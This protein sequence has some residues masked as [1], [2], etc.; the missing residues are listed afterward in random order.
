[1]KKIDQRKG[2]LTFFVFKYFVPEYDR[3]SLYSD[4]YNLYEDVLHDKGK[5]YA[6]FWILC[7]IIRSIPG[8][9]SAKIF[10]L[11]TMLKNY[12]KIVI[13]NFKRHK[14]YTIINVSGLAVGI[15]AC[16]LIFQY[17]SFE[18]SFENFH[19]NGNNIYRIRYDA[20][21]KGKLQYK[22]AAAVPA[23][24]PAM[25]NEFS[26]IKNF[27]RI[28]INW[29]SITVLYKDDSTN[30]EISFRQKKSYYADNS[31][32]TMFT[33]PFIHGKPELALSEPYSVV[34]SEDIVKKYFKN[35]PPVGKRVTINGND[36]KVTG[37]FKNILHNSHLKF[38]VI[39][40]L[41]HF[42]KGSLDDWHWD[43]FYTYVLIDSAADP[44][45]IETKL[46]QLIAKYSTKTE[47]KCFLQPLK[48]IHL[49]SHLQV[50][51]ENN[52][53]GTI[54]HFLLIV[55]IIILIIAWVNYINLS[56][57]RSL[58]RAKESGLR[59][60]SGATRFQLI[61]QFV[62]ESFFTN[63]FSAILAIILVILLS[64]YFGDYFGNKFSF[65][66]LMNSGYGLALVAIILIGTLLTGLYPAFIISSFNLVT[67][68]KGKLKH[69][70]RGTFL[71]KGLVVFQFSVSILLL[72]GTL[73]V[74]RQLFFMR[75]Q[76]LGIDI[77]KILV[78]KG[79]QVV[80]SLYTKK[81]GS[82]ENELLTYP[83]INNVTASLYVPGKEID[84]TR[85]IKR[86]GDGTNDFI[87]IFNLGIDA[88]F[89]ETYNL[90]ILAG[91]G[92]SK[93][94]GT[95]ETSVLLNRAATELLGFEN[96]EDALNQKLTFGSPRPRTIIGVVENYFHLSVKKIPGPFV[97]H[98][99]P[100]ERNFYS[101][102]INQ[103]Q[104]SETIPKIE[105]KW[106]QFFPG[107]PF[108]Y[109]F[110]D[111][112]FDLQYKQDK[113]L[114]QTF[115]LFAFLAMLIACLGLFGLSSLLTIQRTKEIGIRKVMGAR[116][117]SILFLFSK[118]F[119]IL[120]FISAMISF[121]LFWYG[122]HI[123]LQNYPIRI[124]VQAGHFFVA[125]I[126]TTTVAF[127]AVSYQTVK[128]ASAN[129][130]EALRYE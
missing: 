33:F 105:A 103:L 111:E 30:N 23:L 21:S 93:K 97:F 36:F 112:Y 11:S 55:A 57:A 28:S 99:L 100:S 54:V 4:F 64:R 13:R 2:S 117:P 1:M 73:I 71:R 39:L 110:L 49:Y 78:L 27:A 43:D 129:P 72:A 96:P 25:K 14:S 31:F 15:A 90:K 32:F 123:W 108:E 94:Y 38:D 77:N 106:V 69:S 104:L 114:G 127:A 85:G 80:D 88:N 113:K 120:I 125:L 109:F 26:E 74:F 75:N 22:S 67:V 9:L 115:A 42:R 95:N 61:R 76:N 124:N 107:N 83:G 60:I 89:I 47:C 50:E 82:F 18:K 98:F 86:M 68:L 122:I 6:Q 5:F 118:E 91:R 3:D 19:K 52:G 79:P 17:V 126:I 56:T 35:D 121:P 119:M 116:L 58:D 101:V 84:W 59:K 62:F 24:G 29:G 66:F 46:S 53:N 45:I 41:K 34:F 63:I 12:L 48:D 102:K 8:M 7:Q 20:Y 81:Y 51:A 44:N 87:R 128:V 40:D 16:I 65:A 92:F 37:V 130:V 70:D 10:W